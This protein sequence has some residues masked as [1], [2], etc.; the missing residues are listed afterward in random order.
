[1]NERNKRIIIVVSI[2]IIHLIIATNIRF[3]ARENNWNWIIQILL[4]SI[5]SFYSVIGLTS[6]ANLFD[7]KKK[8]TM[9]F[10]VGF[11]SLLYEITGDFGRTS[12]SGTVIDYYD[13]AAILLGVIIAYIIER[14]F[15]KEEKTK[16]NKV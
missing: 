9:P 11:A 12:G 6:L 8:M 3:L 7:K 14:R 4:G 16:P 15:I 5:P 2:V 1:M 10:I 13:I